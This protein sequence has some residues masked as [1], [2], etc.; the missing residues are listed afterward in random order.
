VV[1]P[2]P[3]S[4][5]AATKNV[6]RRVPGVV[7]AKRRLVAAYRKVR[8]L[9][10]PVESPG[11]VRRMLVMP[12]DERFITG[13]G[14]AAH[15][16]YLLNYDVFRVDESNDNDWWFCNPEFLE[17]FFRRVA[18]DEP[19]VLF[20]HNSNVDRPID[21][22]FLPR[23][24]RPELVAWF[25]VNVELEHPK[26]HSIPLGIGNPIKCDPVELA[27]VQDRRPA[28]SEL[29]ESSF[30]TWTNPKE[31]IYCI[32]Q[33]GIE[34]A[35]KV[36]MSQFFERLASSYFCISPNGNGVDCYRTWQALY[37]RTIPIVT[38]SVLT[39]QHPD[40]PLVVLDDWSEFRTI[41]FSPKLY[42]ETWADFDPARIGLDRYLQRVRD[43][44]KRVDGSGGSA[45]VRT[46]M[47]SL[48]G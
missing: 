31:R 32:E 24:E 39:K 27:R 12:P 22:R 11:L 38:R 33:T 43:V 40:L 23:L 45:D 48:K 47:E 2:E 6:F 20:T 3:V 15:C 21:E 10:P 37:L 28:K 26:L 13:N 17:Y 30:E 14:F 35:A 25:A 42:E 4:V 1:S 36:S 44:L 5:I 7:A 8:P 29:F 16:R 19:Y 34:P 41:D 9:R 18:P 46:P